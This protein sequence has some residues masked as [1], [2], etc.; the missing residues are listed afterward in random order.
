MTKSTNE[1]NLELNKPQT[2]NIKVHT[3]IINDLSSG[4]YSSPASCIKE[5]V[6]NS[7]DAD[8]KSVIIRV[9]PVNDSITI[10]DDG[11]GMNAVDFDSKFAWISHSTKRKDSQLSE[12]LKRPLIG[13][14]GIGFIAVNEICEELEII[15]SK[16]GEEI[17]FTAHINFREYFEEEASLEDDDT[18]K[19]IIKG[20]YN[21]INQEEDKIEH[22]TIIKLVG[23]KDSVKDIL[24][25]K[26][27][28]DTLLKK[29]NK[30]YENNFIGSMKE[31]MQFHSRKKLKS[32]SEDNAYVQFI[33]DLASYIPVEYIDGAPIENYQDPI[34][35]EII[36]EHKELVFKVDLDGIYMLL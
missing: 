8:A 10:I 18:E 21:L 33:I 11:I 32:F 34:I 35:T 30:N 22:Y 29:K 12:K 13:K 36:D 15:S 26:Q 2:G 23:L 5:L 7:Y 19:G 3:Q 25:G 17:K 28:L 27:Y 16:E 4:I 6:N 14:I 24:N 20:E 9:K 1:I 31:L